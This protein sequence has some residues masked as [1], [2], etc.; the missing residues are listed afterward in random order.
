VRASALHADVLVA[1]SAILSVNCVVVRGDDEA[2]VIDS[3]VLPEELGALPAFVEQARFPRPGALLATH[4]DW[5]HLL[6]RLA[7][8]DL[9]LGCAPSTAARLAA[10]PGTAQREL[11]AFDEELLIERERP[12]A[13]GSIQTLPVP[14]RCALGRHELE[15]HEASGHTGD[16][17]A[18]V[19]GWA[20]VLVAGD[21]LSAVE[22]PLLG[23]GGSLAGYLATLERLRELARAA[24]HV[25]PGHGPLLSA[26][27][28]ERIFEEDLAYLLALSDRR[29]QAALPAGRRNAAQR[30]AHAD[31]V[32][33]LAA[34]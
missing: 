26:E 30:R 29:A 6:G 3:P 8:P 10:A 9:A 15:L 19:I 1:T 31:N 25:V 18:V 12:L 2:F 11:R 7:F 14:G 33:R 22:L 16:G 5:D 32:S 28:A 21:Y 24:A 4:G 17:M 23:E 27:R 20:G 13:L 34:R